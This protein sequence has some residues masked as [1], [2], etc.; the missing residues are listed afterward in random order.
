MTM[1]MKGPQGTA[2]QAMLI[3]LN[4]KDGNNQKGRKKDAHR[5]VDGVE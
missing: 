4:D 1:K 3:A 2:Y 5:D